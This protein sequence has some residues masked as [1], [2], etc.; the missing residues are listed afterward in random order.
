MN[1]IANTQNSTLTQHSNIPSFEF[2]EIAEKQLQPIAKTSKNAKS[3]IDIEEIARITTLAYKDVPGVNLIKL[4]KQ[5]VHDL[6]L[7]SSQKGYRDMAGFYASINITKT[8]EDIES[9]RKTQ[10][11]KIAEMSAIAFSGY[12]API[13]SQKEIDRPKG[14]AQNNQNAGE[15]KEQTKNRIEIIN[16]DNFIKVDESQIKLFRECYSNLI[17]GKVALV[18]EDKNIY[19]PES[20]ALGV[21]E[22]MKNNYFNMPTLHIFTQ[23]AEYKRTDNGPEDCA[24]IMAYYHELLH[25]R[26]QLQGKIPTNGKE[27]INEEYYA[28]YNQLKF[29]YG[30]RTTPEK[31]MYIIAVYMSKIGYE[32]AT[33]NGYLRTTPG[34]IA[35]Y[36]EFLNKLA[37]GE[38]IPPPIN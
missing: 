17:N 9:I 1:K 34:A 13:S 11:S 5:V 26:H 31:V 35:E 18:L 29:M 3:T 37:N 24:D 6:T 7:Y 14:N 21:A 30:N 28:Y 25:T 15:S 27:S 16:Y 20:K 2:V 38:D 22:F 12:T 33:I 32:Q 19:T 23:S 8:A 10:L 4:Q 36:T